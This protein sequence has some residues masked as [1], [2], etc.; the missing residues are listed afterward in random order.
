MGQN[1]LKVCNASDYTGSDILK[2]LKQVSGNKNLK[3]FLLGRWNYFQ[4]ATWISGNGLRSSSMFVFHG[5]HNPEF[6]V[7]VSGRVKRQIFAPL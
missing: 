3:L 7:F 4:T 1:A 2:V 5:H 6:A